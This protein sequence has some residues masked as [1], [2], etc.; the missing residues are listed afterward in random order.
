MNTQV[1]IALVARRLTAAQQDYEV[2]YCK[3]KH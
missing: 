1:D 2:R 3:P